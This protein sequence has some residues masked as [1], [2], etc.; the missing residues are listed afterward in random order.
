MKTICCLLL[1]AVMAGVAVGDE[2][3]KEAR[4]LMEK[5]KVP[6]E[7]MDK[8]SIQDELGDFGV[9]QR[10]I[11]DEVCSRMVED[12][13]RLNIY[14]LQNFRTTIKANPAN[15]NEILLS[16]VYFNDEAQL[17]GG[18]MRFIEKQLVVHLNDVAV[19]MNNTL[20][21]MPE[22]I[23]SW[24]QNSIK[25]LEAGV[26]HERVKN[27]ELFKDFPYKLVVLDIRKSK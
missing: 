15:T 12:L 25:L 24:Y 5:N 2:M 21:P 7:F 19:S 26:F 4:D 18:D 20:Q 11:A 14:N 3:P 6:I 22:H 1:T 23:L 13:M 10:T 27:N 8:T 17:D 16:V 9:Y